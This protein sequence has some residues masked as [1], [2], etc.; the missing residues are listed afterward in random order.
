MPKRL[1]QGEKSRTR[2]LEMLDSLGEWVYVA[3]L[4]TYEV[5]HVNEAF[6]QLYGEVKNGARCFELL[7]GRNEPCDDCSNR[8]ILAQPGTGLRR[9]YQDPRSGRWYESI[10]SALRWFDDRLVRFH[11]ATDVTQTKNLELS[12][13]RRDELYRTLTSSMPSALAYHEIVLDDAGRPVDYIFLDV[14]AA[15]EE[16][17]GL[18]GEDILGRRVTEVIPG[19]QDAD[20]NLIEIY[21][22]VAL[23]GQAK[24][25]ELYFEPFNRWYEVRVYRPHEE[26][27]ATLFTDITARKEAERELLWSRECLEG[28]TDF[29][30]MC[31]ASAAT[32]YVNRAGRE[33][34]GFSVD[35][36]LSTVLIADYHPPEVAQRLAQEALPTVASGGVWTG[37]STLRSRDGRDIPV[38]Q[39]LLGHRD[40]RGRLALYSTIMRDVS[41][42]RALRASIE[43]AAEKLRRSNRDLEQFAYV[44][45]HD[46]QE[47]L[48]MV[49][50]STELVAQNYGPQLD[51]KARRFMGYATEG[52]RRMQTLINDLLTFSRLGTRERP[53][54]PVDC[55]ALVEEV[56]ADLSLRIA[57]EDAVVEVASL[58]T[59]EADRSQL[60][61]VFQNLIGNALKFRGEA[62]PRIQVSAERD[63]Q[64]WSFSVSDNGVGIDPKFA[65]RIFTIFQRLHAR[66]TYEGTGIGLAIVKRVIERHGG[67]VWVESEAG[68]GSR[69]RFTLPTRRSRGQ[70]SRHE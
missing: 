60:R 50:S 20:P 2:F 11:A 52:A 39:V 40:E 5:L 56:L 38:S 58:P 7:H 59:V 64:T 23:T 12:L 54:A 29:V 15:F 48:R 19:I 18:R 63:G 4:D 37:E 43:D 34:M 3:D 47:P 41:S 30:G 46:L 49:A 36:D 9:K 61:Q 69:F 32:V 51:D 42:D 70:R 25:L 44:A 24:D 16:F 6:T 14:N 27:F 10:E 21:G 13:S 33:L 31:D 53:P 66:G 35:E 26:H 1:R 8:E 17:T 45:S 68:K 57:D 22:R 28:T 55:A 65:E 62:A 67:V